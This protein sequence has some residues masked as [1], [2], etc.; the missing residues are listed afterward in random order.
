MGKGLVSF[1]TLDEA[2]DGAERI[3]RD[4]DNHSRAARSLAETYFDSDK[5][6]GNLLDEVGLTL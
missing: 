5:V 1:R 2:V 4:Y 6:L 3:T